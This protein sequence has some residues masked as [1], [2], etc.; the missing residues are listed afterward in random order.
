MK[1]GFKNL[2]ILFLSV[3]VF[4][5]CKKN[6]TNTTKSNE[7]QIAPL[8]GGTQPPTGTADTCDN[9]PEIKA[10]LIPISNLSIARINMQ[11]AS[12]GN[13]ILFIG[14]SHP[15]QTW[16][17]EPVPV[18]IYDIPSNTW[19]FH[20]ITPDN[21]PFTYFRDDATIAVVGNKVLF[22][23]GGDPI[24]D[25]VT[26][27]I[28]IFD[29]STN[30]W[31]TT[32][33]SAPRQGLSAATVGDKVLFAGGSGYPDGPNWG[34]FNR[35]DIYDNSSN[36]WTTTSLS[37]A[38]AGIATTTMG[39]KIYFA[40]GYN[41]FGTSKTIDVYNAATN[42][43]LASHLQYPRAGMGSIA[44]NGNIYWAG[45]GYSFANSWVMNNNVEILNTSSQDPSITCLLGRTGITA[46]K[47]DDNIVF[48]TGYVATN[49]SRNGI[50]FDIYNTTT[51][52]W[53][54]GKLNL[55]VYYAAVIA[56]NN[57]IY[58]AGGTDGTNYFDSLWKLEF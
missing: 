39:N 16:W 26:S 37:E 1:I 14:G 23:G 6:E 4:L 31:S 7:N 25:N 47:K 18:D 8:G 52:T 15:G 38:R 41:D 56:V 2:F 48:F 27:Q 34:Y 40:G 57:T 53:S 42:S 35:V 43:W 24:G 33:L 36:S 49:D 11:C 46:V 13:K 28:D 21:L 45:G 51:G 58:V 20:S 3:F 50:N 29:A 10:T 5:S 44:V 12:V 32:E 54:I 9:R 19:S 17:N 22:A 30:T 55:K